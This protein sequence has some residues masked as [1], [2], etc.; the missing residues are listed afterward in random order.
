M[1]EPP[2][3]RLVLLEP[4]QVSRG[5]AE[6]ELDWPGLDRLLDLL[7]RLSIDA[8]GGISL[9]PAPGGD[10]L[11]HVREVAPGST[12][13]PPAHTIGIA[14]EDLAEAVRRL[15]DLTAGLTPTRS[16]AIPAR[17]AGGD[18]A[19]DG[20]LLVSG[21]FER[22]PARASG[23]AGL[24][25][26]VLHARSHRTYPGGSLEITLGW[27]EVYEWVALLGGAIADGGRYCVVDGQGRTLALTLDPS[28]AASH[29]EDDPPACV[30]DQRD[31]ETLTEILNGGVDR[32]AFSADH[33]DL[34]LGDVALTV[35]FPFTWP[36]RL[37]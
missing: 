1:A 27:P 32:Q 22:R 25:H 26:P 6:L 33:L 19:H 35:V 17:I 31:T 34:D 5:G 13:W 9:A 30:L 15:S 29:A 28:A 3:E 2:N 36:A 21:P 7:G 12:P 16:L 20:A 37:G 10:V 14:R 8:V 4:P 23:A 18:V 11:V 24:P